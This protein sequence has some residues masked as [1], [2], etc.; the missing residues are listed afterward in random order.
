MFDSDSAAGCQRRSAEFRT[1][2]TT[3]AVMWCFAAGFEEHL[4]DPQGE[5]AAAPDIGIGIEHK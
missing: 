2:E 1:R 4:T 5:R 3:G